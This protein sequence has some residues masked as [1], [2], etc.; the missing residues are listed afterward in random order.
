MENKRQAIG[1]RGEKEACDFLVGLGHRIVRR[2]WR[3]G[4][5]EV[6]IISLCGRTLHIV[7]VKTGSGDSSV[8]PLHRVGEGKKRRLVRAA[9]AF[10]HDTARAALPPDLEVCF[11]VISVIFTDDG[12]H[13][14]YY[15]SAFI[16][17]FA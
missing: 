6:D 17:I 9:N 3:C 11:D 13:T 2:N 14:E 7:E 8:D 1:R 15:P 5:L 4:H 10:L 12:P 16:P